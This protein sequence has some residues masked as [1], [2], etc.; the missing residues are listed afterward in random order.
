MGSPRNRQF[1]GVKSR[2]PSAMTIPSPSLPLLPRARVAASSR[3]HAVDAPARQSLGP[4]RSQGTET[5][6]T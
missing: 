2:R 6:A 5:T 3:L 1:L 4:L